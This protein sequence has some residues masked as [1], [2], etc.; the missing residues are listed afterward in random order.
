MSARR[1]AHKSIPKVEYKDYLKKAE[2]FYA[3]M[4]DC[5]INERWDSTCLEAVHAVISVNDALTIWAKGIRCASPRHEDAVVLLQGLTE[6][7]GV[8]ENAS[9]ILRV[10]KK[11]NAVEYDR[12]NFTRREAE[13]IARHVERFMQ[14]VKSILPKV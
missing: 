5:L 14:W 12:K 6:L 13:D 4:Q 9:H 3:T 2:E 10:I 7:K 8:K 11:K 1:I